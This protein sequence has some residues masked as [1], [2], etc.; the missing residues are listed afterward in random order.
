M[1][2][3]TREI[4]QNMT[5]S[6]ALERLMEGNRRFT[7]GFRLKIPLIRQV[8]KTAPDQFPF[9]AILACSDSRSPAEHIFH[10]GIGDIFSVRVA[11]NIVNNDILGSLEYSCKVVGS[12]LILVLGHTSC[13][14]VTAACNQVKLGNVTSLL[15]KLRPAIDSFSGE[16]LE[17]NRV[18][19]QNVRNSIERIRQ[20]S[21][22]LAEME[23]NG[24]ILIRGAMYDLTT[25]KVTLLEE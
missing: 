24:E 18:A 9:A 21:S 12:K 7:S 16:S 10:L 25:G 8:R 2:T 5:P 3:I 20:E 17:V 23:D 1:E 19:G 13:G 22:I 4:Q 14:A 6:Q 15:S 11:G